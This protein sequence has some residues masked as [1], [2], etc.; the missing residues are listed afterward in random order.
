MREG[1]YLL[2][3]IGLGLPSFVFGQYDFTPVF[4]GLE[5]E[6][7]FDSLQSRFTAQTVLNYSQARDTFLR[8][9]D[10]VDGNVSCVYTGYEIT[11]PEDQDPTTYAFENDINTEHTYPRSK[12]ALEGTNA[13]S[14]MHH[15]FPS[16]VDVNTARGSLMFAEIPDSNTDKWYANDV[17]LTNIPSNNIDDYSEYETGFAFEPR[18]VHKGNVARAYFYFFTI[19]HDLA[20]FQDEEFF[21]SQRETLC[22]WH[23]QDPVDEAEWFR[24]KKIAEYQGGVENPFV[25]DC[26]LARL[27]CDS[28]ATEC[29][30]VPT[31]ETTLKKLNIKPNPAT[32]VIYVGELVHQYTISNMMGNQISVGYYTSDGIDITSLNNGIYI[33]VFWDEDGNPIGRSRFVKL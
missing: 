28:I 10:P 19:Y 20:L 8:N 5:G 18:E 1:I 21:E 15:L 26:T 30:I 31:I 17:T 23:F 25:L 4:P 6:E 27:Y 9:I 22:Q 11:I 33:L 13:Y 14:D 3:F 16:R 24:S 12:G 32:N 7:L 29:I 2:L